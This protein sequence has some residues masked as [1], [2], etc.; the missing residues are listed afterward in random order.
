LPDLIGDQ[1]HH[2]PSHLFPGAARARRADIRSRT[3][4]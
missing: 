1:G 4:N 3:M 2:Q